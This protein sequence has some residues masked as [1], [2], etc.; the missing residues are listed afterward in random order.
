MTQHTT[1]KTLTRPSVL[2]SDKIRLR[3]KLLKDAINDYRWRKDVELCLLDATSP[4]LISFEEYFRAYAEEVKYPSQGRRFAIETL[5]GRHIGNCAYF[6][7]N[8]IKKEAEMGIMVGDQSYWNLGYGADALITL[9]NHVFSQTRLER[10]YLKTLDWNIRA[11]KCFEKC[12][13]VSCGQLAQGDHRFI[14]MERRRSSP[15][16]HQAKDDCQAEG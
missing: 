7:I 9:L 14:I 10:I 15:P 1:S 6:S 11:Q 5:D 12:G 13:F 8:E 2:V 4:I 3:P 16:L